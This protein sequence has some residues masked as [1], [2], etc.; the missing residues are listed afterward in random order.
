M[1]LFI[2]KCQ[3]IYSKFLPSGEKISVEQSGTLEDSPTSEGF[4]EYYAQFLAIR[5]Y[6][7][8][9]QQFLIDIRGKEMACLHLKEK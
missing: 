4:R 3:L 6:L 7:E 1:F 8:N 2:K 9:N 5:A